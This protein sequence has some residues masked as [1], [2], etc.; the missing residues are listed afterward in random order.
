[1]KI[2]MIAPEPIFEPR[3][4]PLSVVG[5]LKAFSDIGY[6]VDLLTYSI[7]EDINLPGINILRIP[8]IPG[9]RKVKIGPSLK[10]IPLDVCLLLKSIATLLKNQYDLIH[11]HEEA[12]FWGTPLSR[13]FR[14]PHIYDMHSSLPQQ[15]KNFQF[16]DSRILK[17]IFQKLE[18]WVIQYSSSVITICPDLYD[19]VKKLFYGDKSVLVENVVD[20]GMIF[21]E[22][23][24]SAEIYKNLNLNGKTIAL[25]A[26]T[27]EPYQGLDLLICCAKTVA[28]QLPSIIF[29]LV[30]GRVDQM[31]YYRKK[32]HEFGL[33]KHF[34]FTGQVSPQDVNSYIRCA[35]VLLSPRVTGTNTPLKIYSYL[36][37]GVPIVAT[38]L[39]THT[40]VLN[41]EV[42]V[43]TE[44]NS[45]GFAQGILSVVNN[46]VLAKS[47]SQKS[48]RI[49]KEKYSYR[50][51]LSKLQW[52][53]QKA[54][55]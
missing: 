34:I 39:P 14:I 38:R 55:D 12:G 26:G 2:L 4:T 5:R 25:Y 45:E 54:I 21:G 15:L 28:S 7:G 9:V 11:S 24:D 30:G 48:M 27:F 35:N 53:I 42:A 1:M 29:L 22:K 20:Y 23:N 18:E 32:V 31:D 47:I 43:L 52:A 37:S 8:R 41:D 16:S 3:G 50:V 13:I 44:P 17:K 40:Q 10:K 19:Y 33:E 51:Y 6:R 36:R 49:T 46:S